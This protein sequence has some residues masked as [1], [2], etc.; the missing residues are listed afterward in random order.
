M[1]GFVCVSMQYVFFTLRHVRELCRC[2]E[3][4]CMCE[5][6]CVCTKLLAA[7]HES[8]LRKVCRRLPSCAAILISYPFVFIW[9]LFSCFLIFFLF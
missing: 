8:M 7:A 2:G 1:C 3:F 4:L 5:V 9:Y 6:C